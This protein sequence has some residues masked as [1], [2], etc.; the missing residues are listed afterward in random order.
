MG[1]FGTRVVC[2]DVY[3][4]A[5]MLMRRMSSLSVDY[6][7]TL[8]H[9]HTHVGLLMDACGV[10]DVIVWYRMSSLSVD[11]MLTLGHTHT[12]T[13]VG[14]LMDTCGMYDVIVWYRM[15]SLSVDYILTLVLAVLLA[16]KYVLVD[17][18]DDVS[19]SHDATVTMVTT[20]STSAAVAAGEVTVMRSS[21]GVGQLEQIDEVVDE[22]LHSEVTDDI[23][24]TGSSLAAG[25]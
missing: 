9:T 1:V 22:S 25:L 3:D 14:L 13:H 2:M 17:R 12:H 16:V 11:Y 7:L 4:V 24:P 8:G 20:P 21:V 6:M 5:G 10:Y 15:S 23:T 18:D 19:Q